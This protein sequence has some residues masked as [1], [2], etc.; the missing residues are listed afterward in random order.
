M[1]YITDITFDPNSRSGDWQNGGTPIDPNNVFGATKNSTRTIDN[2]KNPPTDTITVD[3]DP[4]ANRS[5][6]TGAGG[7]PIGKPSTTGGWG[8]VRWNVS[9]LYTTVSGVHT[10]LQSGHVYRIQF[11]VHDGDQNKVGGDAGGA[12]THIQ[13]Q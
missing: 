10:L 6:S 1:L 7:D 11:M 5:V 2:T 13:V 4:A 12:C 9:S 8:G 3:A